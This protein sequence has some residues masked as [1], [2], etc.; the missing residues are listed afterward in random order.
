MSSGNP[1]LTYLVGFV[2]LSDAKSPLD[3]ESFPMRPSYAPEAVKARYEKLQELW[4][5][6]ISASEIAITLGC[7]KGT[8]FT[9]A[10]KLGLKRRFS[11]GRKPND[12]FIPKVEPITES[13]L[14]KLQGL[15]ETGKP[16]AAIAAELG[17]PLSTTTK[18]IRFYNLATRGK[19]KQYLKAREI[20]VFKRM[21][22]NPKIRLEKIKERFPFHGS[23][24]F[25]LA[26]QLG[27]RRPRG[28]Q[29]KTHKA[30]R[31]ESNRTTN[32]CLSA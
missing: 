2:Y 19:R 13:D 16:H 18:R 17:W 32:A 25:M 31:R 26:H 6:K 28:G 3:A 1:A 29:L 20:P 10:G 7:K 24:L 14:D 15:L 9:I 22:V 12:L 11:N 5:A 21:W 23:V 4:K 27:V 30:G 8:V